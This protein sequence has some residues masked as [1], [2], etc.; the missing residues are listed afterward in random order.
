MWKLE[1]LGEI[2]KDKW[3][4]EGA[5]IRWLPESYITPEQKN[6]DLCKATLVRGIS[7]WKGHRGLVGQN[8]RGIIVVSR[9][10]ETQK[11]WASPN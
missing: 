4:G 5:S 10:Q 3:T 9:F 6:Q 8:S 7:F 2:Y 11:E 1:S